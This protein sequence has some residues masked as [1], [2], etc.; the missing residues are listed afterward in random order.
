MSFNP[1]DEVNC[2]YGAPMGR[3]S[4]NN[5]SVDDELKA[6]PAGDMAEGYDP[7]GAY[8]GA[9]NEDGWIW[10]VWAT[11]DPAGTVT[12]VRAIGFGDA[13]AKAL[14]ASGEPA[15]PPAPPVRARDDA[16]LEQLLDLEGFE[17]EYGFLEV[18]S[19][20]SLVLGICMNEGCD[21][22][23][24][25]EPDQDRGFCECCGTATV[26]SGLILAGAL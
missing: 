13:R 25:Y 6:V 26:K 5:L 17:D 23:T 9:P 19:F 18:F 14:A 11:H 22:T 21:Y 7:G 12:Y 8:W 2:R 1:F 10:A 15:E 4:N 20:E 16:K 3:H 24:E